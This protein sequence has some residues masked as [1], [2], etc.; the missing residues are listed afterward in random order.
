MSG[1]RTKRP[2]AGAASDPAQRQITSFFNKSAASPSSSPAASDSAAPSSSATTKTP[3]NGLILPGHV[4]ANLLS[5]GMRVRKSVPEGYKTG[6]ACSAFSLWSDTSDSAPIATGCSAPSTSPQLRELE[7]FCG[8]NRVGG[9]AVQQLP[10]VP[11]F[12]G[13]R[14]AVSVY[15]DDDDDQMDTTP[16]VPGLTSSQES[17]VS[18]TESS[19]ST[20]ANAP[21]TIVPM[22]AAATTRKRIYVAEDEEAGDGDGMQHP[23]ALL[24]HGGP[25]RNRQDWL[26]GEMSPRSLAPVGWEE[27]SRVLAVPKRRQQ[28]HHQ[29][30]QQQNQLLLSPQGAGV[31]IRK[32]N[33]MVVD[34]DDFQEA[35]FLDY[36]LRSGGSGI[37]SDMDVE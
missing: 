20:A 26:D 8:L 33:I 37:G 3:F 1:L 5:V 27:N 15:N 22:R 29:Q 9:L 13:R 14:Q 28:P 36:R 16:P 21:A 18:S 23:A 2:F 10:A 31:G 17:A 34:E 11:S 24:Q 32:E 25:W 7:P 4:Q 30:Q 12:G 6:S 35:A 19:T